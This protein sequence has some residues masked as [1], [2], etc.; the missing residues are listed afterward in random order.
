[1]RVL[2]YYFFNATDRCL[3]FS[4][5]IALVAYF[6]SW[7][8]FFA[9]IFSFTL[10]TVG[11]GARC[12]ALCLYSFLYLCSMRPCVNLYWH[13]P[14]WWDNSIKSLVLSSYMDSI[15]WFSKIFAFGVTLSPILR[16]VFVETATKYPASLIL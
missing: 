14:S 6:F 5:F 16:Q 8:L 3:F 9:L 15:A 12:S 2:C 7:R 11:C 1:M 4:S 10:C 13:A